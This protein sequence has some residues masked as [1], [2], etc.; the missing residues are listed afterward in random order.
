M[1]KNEDKYIKQMQTANQSH[2]V[3]GNATKD[4]KRKIKLDQMSL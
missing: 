2:L 1:E 3:S 4:K